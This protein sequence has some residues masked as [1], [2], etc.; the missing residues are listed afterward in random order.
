MSRNT[1]I[2]FKSKCRQTLDIN[3]A[4]SSN[5]AVTQNIDLN[6]QRRI[7]RKN[8]PVSYRQ[9][10]KERISASIQNTTPFSVK[11]REQ[12]IRNGV[13]TNAHKKFLNMVSSQRVTSNKGCTTCSKSIIGLSL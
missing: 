3:N 7:V 9:P 10:L 8:K 11:L 4:I 5:I 12:Y 13:F 2:C 1:T 6:F